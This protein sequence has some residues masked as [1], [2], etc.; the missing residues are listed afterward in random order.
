MEG[1]SMDIS[2]E[3]NC[4][5]QFSIYLNKINQYEISE[6]FKNILYIISFLNCSSSLCSIQIEF[7]Q[8]IFQRLC[9]SIEALKC[10]AFEII[11]TRKLFSLR[12]PNNEVGVDS[13]STISPFKKLQD[14][15]TS[16]WPMCKKHRRIFKNT[17]KILLVAVRRFHARSFL[18][19]TPARRGCKRGF[20]SSF[21]FSK[22]CKSERK[23]NTFYK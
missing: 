12:L 6:K 15:S 2:F 9:N 1:V 19:T 8:S 22:F 10:R 21:L 13:P 23:K 16:Q 4:V 7:K 5:T 18:P 11:R 3:Q 14:L 20:W 17:R